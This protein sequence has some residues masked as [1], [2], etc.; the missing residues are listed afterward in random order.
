MR[1]RDRDEARE[2]VW[3]QLILR[4]TRLVELVI[5]RLESSEASTTLHLTIKGQDMANYQLNAGDSV[6]VT[7]T[8]TDNVTGAVVVADAG[9]VSA[10][11]TSTTDILTANA[12]GTFS[13]T[14]GATKGTGNTVTVSATVGG[15]AS[16][17]AVGTYD[18]VGPTAGNATTLS[19]AFGTETGPGAVFPG[20][21][22]PGSPVE[23]PPSNVGTGAG[24]INAITGL[25][26]P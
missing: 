7:V 4:I 25:V 1:G 5:A 17:A 16:T 22:F 3:D 18:V 14:A 20:A 23:A 26:N 2:V 19:V 13:I 12:D 11:L 24:Q 21:V 15:A 9:S 10:V 6:V 8:D